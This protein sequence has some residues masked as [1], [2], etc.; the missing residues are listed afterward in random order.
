MDKRD[1]YDI[2]GVE[3]AASL[4]DIKNAY[5]KLALKYHPDRNPGD[6]QAEE[7]FKE[8]AEAYSVLSDV[9]KRARYDRFGHAGVTPGAG[10]GSGGFDPF[11]TFEDLLGEF[12]GFGEIFG[13]ATRRRSRARAGADLRYDVEL[14]LEE[15][16]RGIDKTLRI[17]RMEPCTTCLGAGMAPGTSVSVC[18]TC[19][20]AGQVRYQQGFFTVSRT[21]N[22]CHGTGAIIKNPCP[23]CRGQGRVQR[24][25]TLEVKIPAGVDTGSRLR[26]QGEG[27]AGVGGGGAGDLYVVIHVRDHE[28]FQ[29]QGADLICTIPITFTQAVLGAELE[30]PTLLNGEQPLKIPPG[31]QSG[32]VFRLQ[33]QGVPKLGKSSRGDFYINVMVITPTQLSREQKRLFEELAQLEGNSEEKEKSLLEKMKK[34]LGGQP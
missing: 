17:P 29:R 32:S 25:K 10:V 34:M 5:R 26:I 3:R 6:K 18:T 9:D 14:T 20:G 11:T 33:G 8:L 2:L 24:E 21:C 30:I 1:Y 4:Q 19:G 27:E 23:D 12:F 13:T 22:H 31:T 16:A 28:F 15:A 7:K